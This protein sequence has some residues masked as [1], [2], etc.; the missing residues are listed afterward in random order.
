MLITTAARCRLRGATSPAATGAGR[1]PSAEVHVTTPLPLVG[2]LGLDR[3]HGGGRPCGASRR[4]R[5]LAR[6]CDESGSASLEFITVGLILLVPLVYLVLALSADPGRGRSR[7]EGAARQ[8]ARVYVQADDVDDG[9][10]RARSG[11]AV[12][13]ADY[14]LAP[15]ESAVDIACDDPDPTDCLA[16]RRLRHRHGARRGRRCPWCPTCS[17]SGRA[18]RPGARRRPTQHRVAV[19]GRR[20]ADG[21]S[22]P[23]GRLRAARVDEERV[24]PAARDLF[25]FL[26]LVVILGVI[27]RDLA[28]PRARSA[29]FTLADGAALAGARPSTLDR[30]ARATDDGLRA[31]PR[32]DDVGRLQPSGYLAEAPTASSRGSGSSRAGTPD[33]RSA[34]VALSAWWRP[35][36]LVLV[37]ARRHAPRR[38]E[39]RPGPCSA[40]TGDG[41]VG[42]AV[43]RGR[44][45]RRR[46]T[47]RHV[48]R[49]VAREDRRRRPARA[50][51]SRRRRRRCE[52]TAV[53]P[54]TASGAAAPPSVAGEAP[55]AEERR[56][57]GRRGEIGAEGHR[58]C[59]CRCRS[60]ATG[61]SRRR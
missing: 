60:R 28:L 22:R 56:R 43:G 23:V 2:L 40:E 38:H 58:G 53:M 21:R 3:A 54:A 47:P 29:C 15:A 42:L 46:G 37:A 55:G 19:L 51:P 44:A 26:G 18:E 27:G 30:R 6:R 13:L 31:D 20:R 57:V 48:A 49:H 33:G 9:P 17:R 16:P 50:R 14:G 41:A 8:A 61:T 45:G 32:P 24:D 52:T 7:A 35:P 59:R 1:H 39:R 11:V 36:V 10:R 34:E 4:C 5:E 12:A 25:M